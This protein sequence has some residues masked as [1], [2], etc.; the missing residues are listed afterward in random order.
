MQNRNYFLNL[1]IIQILIPTINIAKIITKIKNSI[2]YFL[3]NW[4]FSQ[5]QYPK[6]AKKLTH[7]QA[8]SQVYIINFLISILKSPAGKLIYCLIKGI[9]LQIKVVIS[10]YF[11]K[12]LT[13]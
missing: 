10:Q 9:S 13:Q 12:N 6:N 5:A 2:L 8:P 7:I 1:F 4:L 11:S 3:I